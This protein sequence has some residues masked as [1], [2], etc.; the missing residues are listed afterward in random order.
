MFISW[1]AVYIEAIRIGI[2]DQ[3]YAIPVVALALNFSWEIIH[4]IRGIMY[5]PERASTLWVVSWASTDL[6]I[7]YTYFRYGRTE[8]PSYITPP[9]FVAG[10][11]L[12]F[13]AAFFVQAAFELEISGP[14]GA[15]NY[16][17]FLQNALMSGLFIAMFLARGGSRG[18]SLRLAIFK[19]IGSM[20]PVLVVGRDSVY[21]RL[22]GSVIVMLDIIYIGLLIYARRVGGTLGM[23]RTCEVLK[24]G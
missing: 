8:F 5:Y 12:V 6:G 21:V 1:T 13:V 7:L 9:I 16:A 24:T 11:L 2:R 17:A 14:I 18:Q 10:S 3:T 20:A 19:G 23:V 4:G 15:Y 22:V